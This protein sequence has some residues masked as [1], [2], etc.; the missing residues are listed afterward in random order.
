MKEFT[1]NQIRNIALFSHGGAGK[2]SLAEA[3]L[4]CAKASNRL[5]KVEDGTTVLDH[6][7]DEVQRK[8]TI[9]LALAQFEWK[10][11]KINLLDTP[12]YADFVGEVCSALRAV[13][14]A[15]LVLRASTGVEVGTELVWERIHEH[16]IPRLRRIRRLPPR[17]LVHAAERAAMGKDAAQARRR[18][19]TTSRPQRR[20]RHGDRFGP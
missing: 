14:A 7:P 3:M 1:T 8:I 6:Q 20:S 10:G 16:R 11:V 12:G 15:V 5:G 4:F 17:K 13:D 9:N 19:A 2:T 18:P